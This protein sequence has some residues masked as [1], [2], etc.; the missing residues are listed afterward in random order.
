MTSQ[1]LSGTTDF[2][3]QGQ[4]GLQKASPPP[5]GVQTLPELFAH[6]AHKHPQHPALSCS[7]TGGGFHTMS[8]SDMATKVN[9][10]ADTL[11]TLLG[12]AFGVAPHRGAPPVVGIW[13]ERSLDLTLAVLAA[14]T[15][16]STWLPFDPD[17]PVDRVQACLVDS[18]ATLLLCDDAHYDRASR[19]LK[20]SQTCKAVRINDVTAS[21]DC[22][23]R[24]S[25]SVYQK[26]IG[27]EDPAYLIYTSGSELSRLRATLP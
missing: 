15:A 12:E 11:R 6:T 5:D 18:G 16:G 17:A 25:S 7:L 26:R 22:P 23:R 20:S 13:I 21:N 8:Y 27:P 4:L 14:T 10:M 24:T 1:K 3:L 2:I 9:R 19:L